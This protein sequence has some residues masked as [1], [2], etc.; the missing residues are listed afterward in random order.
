MKIQN[1][2]VYP[3]LFKMIK[4]SFELKIF[5]VKLMPIR[6]HRLRHCNEI[7]MR[8][9]D[10]AFATS[11][12][13]IDFAHGSFP[14]LNRLVLFRWPTSPQSFIKIIMFVTVW[15]TNTKYIRL[16]SLAQEQPYTESYQRHFLAG[17]GALRIDR[18]ENSRFP[19]FL[20]CVPFW[21]QYGEPF[22]RQ[23]QVKPE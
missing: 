6:V 15:G 10:R 16:V 9:I 7:D 21:L 14:K 8:Y 20:I 22:Y 12:W 18:G 2:L 13:V 3:V 19:V 4:R 1:L 23:I 11:Y 17:W 5:Q